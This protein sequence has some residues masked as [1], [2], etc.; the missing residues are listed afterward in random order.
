MPWLRFGMD[1][2]YALEYASGI[3]WQRMATEKSLSQGKKGKAQAFVGMEAK[4]SGRWTPDGPVPALFLGA[5]GVNSGV[6]V[7][8]SQIKWAQSQSL[9]LGRWTATGR[10]EELEDLSGGPR[11]KPSGGAAPSSPTSSTSGRTCR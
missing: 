11:R 2:A 7:V 6:P 3:L 10:V 8:V 4:F 5:T 1:R 9:G